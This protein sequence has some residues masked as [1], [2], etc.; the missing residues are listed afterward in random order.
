MKREFLIKIEVPEWVT[1]YSIDES[2]HV[3]FY[4]KKPVADD[5]EDGGMW[6]SD[7]GGRIEFS[8]IT[9]RSDLFGDWRQTLHEIL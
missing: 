9:L 4:E 7:G 8:G 2:G 5:E 3:Y 1:C 6:S